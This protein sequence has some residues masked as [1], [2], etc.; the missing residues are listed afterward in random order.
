MTFV[1]DRCCSASTRS[2][3]ELKPESSGYVQPTLTLAGSS[4]PEYL[5]N[6]SVWLR[7]RQGRGSGRSCREAAAVAVYA[8]SKK[9]ADTSFGTSANRPGPF[10]RQ[11]SL[12]PPQGAV[13][14]A[15]RAC[16]PVWRCKSSTQ[17]DGGEGL[18]KR[19][20]GHREV[21]SEGSVE[22]RREPMHKNRIEGERDRTSERKVAKSVSVKGHGRRS[23]GCAPKAVGL[24]PGG[25]RRCPERGT[26]GTERDPERGAG[27]SRRHSRWRKRAGEPEVSHHRRPERLPARG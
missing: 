7:T 27:V 3:G 26:E 22:Q 20:G 18:A 10:E 17:P 23:G 13:A 24:T 12:P 25:L 9:Q 15:C 16:P 21:A 14:D 1:Y 5:V 19:K 2:S 11:S 4:G 6:T 8:S